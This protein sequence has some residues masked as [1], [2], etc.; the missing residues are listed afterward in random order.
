MIHRLTVIDRETL[1]T[2]TL[3]LSE[4]HTEIVVA[5]A[6]SAIHAARNGRHVVFVEDGFRILNDAGKVTRVFKMQSHERQEDY[7]ADR[8]LG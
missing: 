7:D 1:T 6:T 3:K 4:S 5:L 8:L 2:R